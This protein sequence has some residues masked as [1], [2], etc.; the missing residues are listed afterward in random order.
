MRYDTSEL[1]TFEEDGKYKKRVIT[2]GY[3]GKIG[4]KITGM[5]KNDGYGEVLDLIVTIFG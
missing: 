5:F 1:V 2:N 4:G 3:I